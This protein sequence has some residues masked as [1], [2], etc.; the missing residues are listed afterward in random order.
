VPP[1][2]TNDPGTGC[3]GTGPTSFTGVQHENTDSVY[4]TPNV[5][6]NNPVL[7]AVVGL[8]S[9]FSTQHARSF[10]PLHFVWPVRSGLR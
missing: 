4:W 5:N 1:S 7:A 2:L 8:S 9:G 10:S 3:L 6:E